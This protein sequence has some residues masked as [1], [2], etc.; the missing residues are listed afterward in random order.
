MTRKL[1]LLLL[2]F[3]PFAF[4]QRPVISTQFVTVAPDVK[5]EVVDWGGSGRPLVLLAGL[6]NDAHIFD[7]FAAKLAA[8]YHVYGITRRGFGGSSVPSTDDLANYKSD[9]LADDILAVIDTLKLQMPIL[10]GHSIAGE[11]L[12][13]IGTRHPEKVS[14]LV[15]LD[16]GYP[17]AF[18][19][20]ERGDVSIDVGDV[21][22]KLEEMFVFKPI[23]Q[24][25][26]LLADLLELLPRLESGLKELQRQL[27]A[28][29]P[30]TPVP[31]ITPQ[32]KAA[33]AIQ[34]G[35][36]RYGGVSCPVLAIYASPHRLAGVP[37][38]LEAQMR[39]NDQNR[40]EPQLAAFSKGNPQ[41]TIIRL[42]NADHYIFL[43]NEQETLTAIDAFVA[44]LPER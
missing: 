44:R 24:R 26:A 25:K 33:T 9:R 11:E 10:A 36:Q 35:E 5:L 42:P 13:S 28:Q 41:A 19:N 17:Y 16:A 12:S 14:G 15:Y 43:S 30:N 23:P 8:R 20:P 21:H 3:S 1:L 34:R 38:D 4:S 32:I 27:E 37:K 39:Q 6:G 7:A 40:V 18:Y 29:N 2:A 31:P 22:Q